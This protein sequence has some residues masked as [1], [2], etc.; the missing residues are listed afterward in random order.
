MP[1]AGDA[2]ILVQIPQRSQPEGIPPALPAML[3]RIV[4]HVAALAERLQVRRRA[5]ARVMIEVRASQDDVGHPDPRQCEAALHRNPLALVRSPAQRISVP[6]SSI[7]EMC[8]PTKVRPTALLAAPAG[9][10]EP[11]CARQLLPVDRV[12]P[13][14]F[15]SDRHRISMSHA[16]GLGK[17]YFTV[18]CRFVSPAFRAETTS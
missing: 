15:G 17:R 10:L 12:E 4:D 14:I 7:A 6:P 9:T 13:A 1:L 2:G 5:V 18:C 8:D 11:D 3:G 16:T